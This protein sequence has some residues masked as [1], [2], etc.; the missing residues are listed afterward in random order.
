MDAPPDAVS[1]KRGT[2]RWCV[3]M[4]GKDMQMAGNQQ[5]PAVQT[6]LWAAIASGMPKESQQQVQAQLALLAQLAANDR[7]MREAIVKSSPALTNGA[8][9]QPYSLGVPLT[10]DMPQ[11]NNG[12][13]RGIIVRTKL[14]I[15]LNDPD[16]DATWAL[17]AAGQDAIYDTIEVRY[18]NVQIKARPWYLRQLALAGALPLVPR[19]S[20][21][22]ASTDAGAAEDDILADYLTETNFPAVSSGVAVQFVSDIWVPFNVGRRN[23]PRGLLP[24]MKGETGVQVILNTPSA[25][26]GP[27]P[28]FNAVTNTDVEQDGTLVLNA[29]SGTT[30]AVIAVFSDGE[31]YQMPAALPYNMSVLDGTIQMLQDNQL[32]NLS[33]GASV[34]NRGKLNIL[35]KHQYVILTC[36]DGQQGSSCVAD[37]SNIVFIS[38]DKDDVGAN[39]FY[40][41][42]TG[43]NLDVQEF[44][45][46]QRGVHRNIDL[47]PGV[48]FMVQA[49]LIGQSAEG[50]L[51]GS[52]YWDN[53]TNGWPALHYG[54]SFTT[55][56]SGAYGSQSVA[57]KPMIEPFTCHINPQGLVPVGSGY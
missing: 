3:T 10:F 48:L 44:F 5:A 39:S 16:A 13:I 1:W 34:V 11:P 41:Y 21:W 22:A 28:I 35:G 55:L 14:N 33:A 9:T 53:T 23:E 12:F 26:L 51:D 32:T 42:G 50:A 37:N 24:S 25:L 31:C 30:A 38:M 2:T 40:R 46:I 15:T 7:Y 49:P 45:R 47:D 52:Q 27:H 29:G 57:V 54:V 6:N 17:T 8:A 36:V 43:T 20:K 19:N 18:N 56:A 4:N